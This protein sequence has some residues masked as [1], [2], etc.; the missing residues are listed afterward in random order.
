MGLTGNEGNHGEDLK[1]YYYYYLD[2]TPMHSYMKGL[3]QYPQSEISYARLVEENRR[4]DQGGL[5]FELIDTGVDRSRGQPDE[6][7]R[8]RRRLEPP[9]AGTRLSATFIQGGRVR[10][11]IGNSAGAIVATSTVACQVP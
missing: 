3:C 4:R 6:T 7:Q 5:E 8:R 11:E 10:G 2:S 1:D 9:G